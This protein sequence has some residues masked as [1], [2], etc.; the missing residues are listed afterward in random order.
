[1]E[2]NGMTNEQFNKVLEM[3]ITIIKLSKSK[4]EAIEEIKKLLKK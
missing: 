3:I 1:M 4:E 2:E